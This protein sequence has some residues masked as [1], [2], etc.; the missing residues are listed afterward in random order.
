ML[1]ILCLSI[2]VFFTSFIYCSEQEVDGPSW[3]GFQFGF[4]PGY[5]MLTIKKSETIDNSDGADSFIGSGEQTFSKGG[6]VGRLFTGYAF[7]FENSF[8]LSVNVFGDFSSVE[9]KNNVSGTQ[10]YN[11][12]T[13]AISEMCKIDHK[14]DWGVNIRPGILV[15]PNALAFVDIGFIKGYFKHELTYTSKDFSGSINEKKWR[16]G[17]EAGLGLQLDMSHIK[18]HLQ[19][20]F[21]GLYHTYDKFQYKINHTDG[22]KY[23]T[24]NV[25]MKPQGVDI[26][27]GMSYL[28]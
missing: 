20:K 3:S 8:S 17:F 19:L 12:S 10:V 9:I 27:L 2:C 11:G 16:S 22:A 6:L 23:S 25:S 14:Q 26:L 1:R 24:R 13:Y 5:R 4:G 21:I 7:E 15:S 18:K 28:F